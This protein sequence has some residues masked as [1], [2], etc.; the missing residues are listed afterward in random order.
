[1]N[2]TVLAVV[3]G[4][5]ALLLLCGVCIVGVLFLAPGVIQNQFG[6]I[7]SKLG[8]PNVQDGSAPVPGLQGTGGP[9]GLPPATGSANQPT[10]PSSTRTTSSGNPFANALT[11][12]QGAQ[13]FRFEVSWVMGSTKGGKYTEEPF[14]SMSGEVDG[15]NSH[16]TTKAGIFAALAGGG[17][18]EIVE[19][20]GKSYWKGVN[21]AGM[22]DPKQWYIQKDSSSSNTFGDF[23]KPDYW[24]G[25]SSSNTS[26]Y[27]KVGSEQLDGQSCDVYL[28]DLKN[29]QNS[30]MVGLLG[31]AQ[32]KNAFS[33]ID[34]AE[35]NF[36]LCGDGFVHKFSFEYSGHDAKNPAD[37][38]GVKWSGHFYD[39]N[40][41]SIKVTAPS[42]AKPMPGQ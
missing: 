26:D 20:D 9:L 25:F 32:D 17:S 16:M 3:G 42:D 27:K 13:K 18:L 28:Y 14:L 22:T 29:V 19:A 15:K 24:N 4:G 23:A 21:L 35:T 11:K 41:A 40:N 6:E 5:C 7:T 10:S 36:W 8:V 37:K 30:A 39:F 38:G 33:A 1:M 31:S 12:A 34:K 2:K